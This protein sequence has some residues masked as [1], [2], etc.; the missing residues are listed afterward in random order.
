MLARLRSRDEGTS[1][2]SYTTRLV[3]S[4]T[5]QTDHSLYL[6]VVGRSAPSSIVWVE[7]SSTYANVEFV[8]GMQ[9]DGISQSMSYWY[10]LKRHALPASA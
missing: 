5:S 1:G 6:S 7:R 4:K 8:M 10:V 2:C 3:S 9:G